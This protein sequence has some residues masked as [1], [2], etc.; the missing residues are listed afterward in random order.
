MNLTV[1]ASICTFDSLF[2]DVSTSKRK[3]KE[4][5]YCHLRH[6]L[7]RVPRMVSSALVSAQPIVNRGGSMTYFHDRRNDCA[8]PDRGGPRRGGGTKRDA[9]KTFTRKG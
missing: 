7:S 9:A 2:I 8:F 5:N 6:M 3:R 1:W 4:D